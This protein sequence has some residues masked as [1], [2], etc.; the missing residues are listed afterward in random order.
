MYFDAVSTA[1]RA[2]IGGTNMRIVHYI[3]TGRLSQKWVNDHLVIVVKL[4]TEGDAVRGYVQT[5]YASN[6]ILPR[7]Q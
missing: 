3:S 4:M 2:L 5:V 6:R 7:L 1:Q